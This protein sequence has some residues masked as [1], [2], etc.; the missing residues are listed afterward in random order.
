M[1]RRSIF[2]LKCHAFCP[3]SC[4]PARPVLSQW[5]FYLDLEIPSHF[6]FYVLFAPCFVL[7]RLVNRDGDQLQRFSLLFNLGGLIPDHRICN[8]VV[9]TGQFISFALLHRLEPA[10]FA[11]TE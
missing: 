8:Q 4:S 3:C 10:V 5:W 6:L 1:G 9:S 7:S 2:G 11:G